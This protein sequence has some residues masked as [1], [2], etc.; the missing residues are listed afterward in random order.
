MSD[1][2]FVDT[3]VL[4]YA[5]DRNA[6]EK[7]ASALAVMEDLWTAGIGVLSTQVLQEFYVNITRK[8]PVP[9]PKATAS[10]YVQRYFLWR[11]VAVTPPTILRAFEIEGQCKISFWDAMI[12]SAAV[13]A[14]STKIL[15]EDLNAGQM[16]AGIPIE[17]PFR[18]P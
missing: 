14:G 7:Y 12:V 10:V 13:E 17:N 11:V 3:N 1:R 18:K 15:S 4:I 5:H 2:I 9:I 16:I 8:I 6:G